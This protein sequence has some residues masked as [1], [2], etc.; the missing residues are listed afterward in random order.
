MPSLS[1]GF[2]SIERKLGIS[3]FQIAYCGSRGGEI[4]EES[5]DLRDPVLTTTLQPQQVLSVSTLD[6]H[7]RFSLEKGFHGLINLKKNLSFP[8]LTFH[9]S[10]TSLSDDR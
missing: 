7:M 6:F 5:V 8:I 10:V 4:G 9:D 2:L 3:Y 1:S